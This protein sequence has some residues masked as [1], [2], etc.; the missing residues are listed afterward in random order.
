MKMTDAIRFILIRSLGNFLLILAFFGVF[1]TFGPA[2]WYEVKFH[3]IQIRGIHFIATAEDFKGLGGSTQRTGVGAL[4]FGPT[5]QILTPVDT[6]FAIVIPKID[7]NA[8][9]YANVDAMNSS[10][11]LPILREGV[12]QAKGSSFPD[13]PGDMYLFAHSTD[14]WWDVGRYNAVFYLL[15]DLIAGDK[16]DI[17]YKG[18]KYE[19]VVTQF[20][21]K[22]PTDTSLL[23]TA[24]K[25]AGHGIILQTCWPP[26]TTWKRL[27]VIAKQVSN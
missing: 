22:D 13:T 27:Y 5:E 1:W 11:F 10:E 12:A 24:S 14:N 6:N 18:K 4:V 26:G 2:L 7:A 8:K 9:I 3:M 19:Y 20:T 23:D 21:L 15:K 16:I 17:F 25:Q